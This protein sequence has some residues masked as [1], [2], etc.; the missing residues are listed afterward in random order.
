MPIKFFNLNPEEEKTFTLNYFFSMED[1][2]NIKQ[3]DLM[4]SAVFQVEPKA[5][6]LEEIGN[7]KS[8]I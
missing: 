6:V 8:K 1:I 3:L 5:K 4:L 7:R 2:Q